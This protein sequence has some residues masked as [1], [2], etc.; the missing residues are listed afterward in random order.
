M[1]GLIAPEDL[2]DAITEG[3]RE[4]VADGPLDKAIAASI[5]EDS[6]P[7][8][9]DKALKKRIADAYSDLLSDIRERAVA[10]GVPVP[11]EGAEIDW[12][13]VLSEM[14]DAQ[15]ETDVE[16]TSDDEVEETRN[17]LADLLGDDYTEGA[18]LPELAAD[19]A[20]KYQ[21]TLDAYS[22]AQ[23]QN[24][25]LVREGAEMRQTLDAAYAHSDK[26]LA[27]SETRGHKS[28]CKLVQDENSDDV[29]ACAA[30]CPDDCLALLREELNHRGLLAA[31]PPHVRALIEET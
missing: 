4:W 5:N 26:L 16:P 28:D 9:A 30:G 7:E 11:A 23:E 8:T 29:W 21:R 6:L 27:T 22:H 13:E 24:A 10:A 1:D 18:P 19:V 14:L 25:R 20:A 15:V 12:S 17:A 31:L 3:G 2:E